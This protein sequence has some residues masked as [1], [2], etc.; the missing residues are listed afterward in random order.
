MQCIL[1]FSEVMKIFRQSILAVSLLIGSSV[2]GQRIL[3]MP[4]YTSKPYHFG[5]YLGINWYNFHIRHKPNLDDYPGYYSTITRVDPGYHVGI[6]SDLRL[7]NHLNLRFNPAFAATVRRLEIDT[8]NP[9]FLRRQVYVKDVES[10]FVELP[11]ELKF[12]SK[13]IHNY[14]VYITGGLRYNI[15]LASQ[16]KVLDDELF[17]IRR[18]D[19]AYEVGFGIDIFFEYFKMSPQLKAGFGFAN[20]LVN[21]GSVYV[22]NIDKIYTRSVLFC[23]TFE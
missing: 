20:L 10:S 23:I 7:A 5:F 15:D 21:D 14:L 19:F 8:Y 3:N 6:I 12:S 22:N 2:Y 16:E 17:K 13:R 1:R 11:L 9:N 4:T 18:N